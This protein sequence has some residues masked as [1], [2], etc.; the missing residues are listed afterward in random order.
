MAQQIPVLPVWQ[1]KQY[2]VVGDGVHGVDC[3]LATSTVFR[4]WKI[5]KG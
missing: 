3:C 4:F 2:A 5:S 1:A